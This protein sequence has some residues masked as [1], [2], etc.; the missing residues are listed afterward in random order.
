MK[1]QKIFF[2]ILVLLLSQ[3]CFAQKVETKNL[4]NGDLIFVE[5]EQENLSGAINRVTQ[6]DKKNSF[7]HIALLEVAQDSI[8]VLHASSKLG[9]IRQNLQDFYTSQKKTQNNLVIY[10]LKKGNLKAI[11]LAIKIAKS[12]LGKPYNWS[13]ILN[14]NSYYCSD[15]IERAFRKFK[16]FTL[17]PMT[18]INPATGQIDTFWKDFY[19]KQGLEVPEGVLG[20]NPNGLAASENLTK[21][22]FLAPLN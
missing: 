7:D 4:K 12:M 17:E 6:R 13:Y 2:S 1:A 3:L 15:F 5:A 19:N 8:F 18:F 20:C 16:I 21:I 14:E 11:P 10:R 9:S 22:G